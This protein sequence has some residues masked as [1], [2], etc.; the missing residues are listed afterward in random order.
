MGEQKPVLFTVYEAA[1][2]LRL[3]KSTLYRQVKAGHV[4]CRLMPNGQYYF[5]PADLE[6]IVDSASRPA[7]A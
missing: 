4:P 6:Q 1:R 7:V 2:I 5:T 3:G